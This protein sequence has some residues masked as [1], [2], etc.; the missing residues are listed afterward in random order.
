LI[1]ISIG[2]S[3]FSHWDIHIIWLDIKRKQNADWHQSIAVISMASIYSC[4]GGR[5][6]CHID[7]HDICKEIIRL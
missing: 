2:H 5:F 3:V 6:Y 1:E 4:S 7:L